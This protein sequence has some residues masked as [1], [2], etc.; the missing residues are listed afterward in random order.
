MSLLYD[1][2]YL[3]TIKACVWP[4][5]YYGIFSKVINDNNF[6]NC[7]EIGIGYGMHAKQ[8]LDNTQLKKLYLI[9]PMQWYSNDGFPPD[10]QKMGGFEVLVK[11]I[12]IHLSEHKDRYKWFR[13]RSLEITNEEIQDESLDAVF[14]DADHSYRA[15]CRDLPFWWKKIK[16]NGWLLG[17]DYNSCHPGTTRAVNEFSRKNNLKLEFLYKNS[18]IKYPI[19]KFVKK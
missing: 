15:V 8:V 5:I 13:K 19:Y 16:K 18:S 17:D 7:A 1:D 4:K 10:V 11:N 12:K 2:K 6:K 3:E 9:D 14:L